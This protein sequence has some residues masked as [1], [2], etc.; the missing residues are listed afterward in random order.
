MN[1]TVPIKTNTK[2]KLIYGVTR[3]FKKQLVIKFMTAWRRR[4]ATS[5]T[6][7]NTKHSFIHSHEP[8]LSKKDSC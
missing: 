7:I 8:V 1:A 4:Q 5:F 3:R 6:L 2:C